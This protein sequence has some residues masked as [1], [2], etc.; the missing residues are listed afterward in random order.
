MNLDDKSKCFK[1]FLS[2]QGGS[3]R[4]I[5]NILLEAFIQ[6]FLFDLPVCSHFNVRKF[7]LGLGED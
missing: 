3:I 7:T 6:A 1:I 2:F 5:G 4:E